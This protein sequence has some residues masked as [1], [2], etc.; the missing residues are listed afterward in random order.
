M[1]VIR[2]KDPWKRYFEFKSIIEERGLIE[3]D[4]RTLAQYRHLVQGM[5]VAEECFQSYKR[6]MNDWL[7]NLERSAIEEIEQQ[8]KKKKQKEIK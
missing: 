4:V 8:T 1:I 3:S 7:K 5:Q 2:S 6:K